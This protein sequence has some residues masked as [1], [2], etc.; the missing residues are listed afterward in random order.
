VEL[1]GSSGVTHPPGW[2][3]EGGGGGEL[4]HRR[5]RRRQQRLTG[6]RSF[7]DG[8]TSDRQDYARSN[9]LQVGHRKRSPSNLVPT[10]FWT[11]LPFQHS[12][13]SPFSISSH[14]PAVKYY[15]YYSMEDLKLLS[16]SDGQGEP[17]QISTKK[18]F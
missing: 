12:L 1:A 15:Y 4:W 6:W 17:H 16:I 8:W 9:S 13:L 2:V 5:C 14:S 18:E 3:G 7:K 10:R 11:L